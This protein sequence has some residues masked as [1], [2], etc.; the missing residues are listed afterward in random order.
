M[1][2]AQLERLLQRMKG[3]PR[4]RRTLLIGIDGGGGSGK[5]VLAARL[6][7]IEAGVTVIYGDD[8]YLP[9]ARRAMADPA[10]VGSSFDWLRIRE[11]VL[12]P[13]SQDLPGRYQRYDWPTDALAEWVEVEPGAIVILEGVYT[14]RQE[15]APFYDVRI[16]VETPYSLRLHRGLERDGEGARHQWEAEWMPAEERYARLHRPDT[17]AHLVLDGTGAG[18]DLAAGQVLVRRAPDGWLDL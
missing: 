8:F 16:W 6:S 10:A 1:Q 11:Q 4:R 15:L 14:M 3:T 2:V 7:E 12:A 9:S 13:L 18:A 17:A 5:S